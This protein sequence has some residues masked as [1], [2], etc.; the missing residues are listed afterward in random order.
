MAATSVTGRSASIRQVATDAKC[1][2][3]RGVHGGEHG[4]AVLVV[5]RTVRSASEALHQD[6]GGRVELQHREGGH[7]PAAVRRVRDPGGCG[8]DGRS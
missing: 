2:G 6:G 8:D 1:A 3:R 5:L 4:Q 7:D